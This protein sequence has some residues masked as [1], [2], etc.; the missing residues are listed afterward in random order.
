MAE[1]ESLRKYEF[2]RLEAGEEIAEKAR[3]YAKEND[4]SYGDAVKK[5]LDEDKDLA[6]KYIGGKEEQSHPYAL[7][8]HEYSKDEV[9]EAS[10]KL[11]KKAQLEMLRHNYSYARAFQIVMKDPENDELVKVYL[12]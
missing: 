9:S 10:D 3:E 7:R 5:V 11:N 4:V 12:S 2:E 6:E 1:S 8:T